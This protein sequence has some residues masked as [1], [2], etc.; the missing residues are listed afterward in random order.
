VG[1]HSTIATRQYVSVAVCLL[2]LFFCAPVATGDDNRA[3]R[4]GFSILEDYDKG[5]DLA[6]VA[7]DFALFRELGVTPGEAASD[8]STVTG[9]PN[10]STSMRT[11]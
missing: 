8:G 6:E 10:N 7:K 2:A 1:Q 4:V 11:V 9:R 5:E 3:K